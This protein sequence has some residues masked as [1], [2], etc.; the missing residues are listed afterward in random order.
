MTRRWLLLLGIFLMLTPASRAEASPRERT[1]AN[2]LRVL[3]DAD[4]LAAGVDVAV[5]YATGLAEEPAARTGVTHLMER[6]MFRGSPG[7][8]AGEYARQLGQEGVS[9][10]T[11]LAPDFS[12]FYC[13]GSSEALATMIKLEA[14]RMAGQRLG[15][16]EVA[17][18]ARILRDEHRRLD[19]NPF[20]HGIQHLYATAFGSH[21]YAIPLQGRAAD[22]A[23]LTPAVCAE[24]SRARYGPGNALVTVVGNFDPTGTEELL[25]R[26]FGALPPRAASRP[27]QAAGPAMGTTRGRV[28]SPL[29]MVMVGWRAPSDSACGAE[30][31]VIAQLLGGGLSPRLAA[32]MVRGQKLALATTCVFDGRRRGSLLY[33]TATVAPVGDS[34]RVENQLVD[35]V[36]RLAREP[37]SEDDL[38]RA[39]KA[40]LLAARIERQSVRGRAQALGAAAIIDGDWRA[41]EGRLARIEALTPRDIQEAA[42]G[43]LRS[44]RRSVVWTMPPPLPAATKGDRR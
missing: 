41:A 26:T 36:E 21:P 1:F 7:Y 42:A 34:A 12:A 40:L 25:A 18:E 22:L 33:A 35:Q 29:R 14:D 20:T 23:R 6:L 15:A 32:E 30:L 31:A 2:G 11:F 27:A 10:N 8:A 37:I 24:Y 16:V 39:G 9:F 3:I 17:A 28:V 19:E 43:I 38:A 13:T 4:S 44:D 5:W